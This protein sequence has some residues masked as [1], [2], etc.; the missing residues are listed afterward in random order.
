MPNGDNFKDI[1]Y[2]DADTAIQQ[3]KD[4]WMRAENFFNEAPLDM[5]EYAVLRLSMTLKRYEYLIRLRKQ[6]E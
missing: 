1:L 5:A 4:E 6:I 2:P 3:A